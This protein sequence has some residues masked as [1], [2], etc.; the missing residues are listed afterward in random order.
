M[1]LLRKE[2]TTQPE[3]SVNAVEYVNTPIN[4]L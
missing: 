2:F 1:P 3:R 4:A